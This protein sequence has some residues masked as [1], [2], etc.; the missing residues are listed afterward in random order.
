MLGKEGN[1]GARSKIAIG[2]YICVKFEA[3]EK[4]PTV[5]LPPLSRFADAN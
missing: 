1:Q 2:A 3:G 5:T 4:D